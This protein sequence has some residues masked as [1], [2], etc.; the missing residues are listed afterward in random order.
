M[1][2]CLIFAAL[3]AATIGVSAQTMKVQSAY[4]DMKNDRWKNAL[5]NIE[6]ACVN[7]KTKEDAKTWNYAGLIYAKF[8]ELSESQDPKDQKL[9]KK[10]KVDIP[11]HELA[12]KA[13]DALIKSLELEK[14]A[15]TNEFTTV[16]MG[17]LTFISSY[18]LNRAVATFNEGKYQECIPLFEKTIEGSKVSKQRDVT[19]KSKL[20]MAMAYDAL[21]Q[22]DKATEIYRELVKD[23]AKEKEAYINLYVANSAAKEMDKAINVLKRGVKVLP[24]DAQL[25]A[26]LGAAYLQA[27]NKAECENM[28]QELLKMGAENPEILNYVE[29]IYRDAEDIAKAEEYYNK[30]L[31]LNANQTD[32]YLGLGTTYFNKGITQLKE[33]EK[34]PLDDMTG[35]YDKMKNEAFEY[36]KKAIPN[37]NKVLETKPNDFQSLK[38]LR[39][40]YSL[41]NMKAEFQAIDAKLKAGNK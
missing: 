41:L 20:V 11:I 25:K 8:V 4:S 21:K 35:A 10:Q 9:L 31:T 19:D 23:G 1:K 33:A 30:S 29:G 5:A 40:I 24:K 37:L 15:G 17:A 22:K 13:Q 16:S 6:E 38:A 12:N 36:F 2:K 27:G 28:I 3:F 39:N 26:L 34:V 18:Q 14:K 32:A 7:D